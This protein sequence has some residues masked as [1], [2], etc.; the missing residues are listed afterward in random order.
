MRRV[1][2]APAPP[3]H[4]QRRLIWLSVSMTRRCQANLGAP[5]AGPRTG[6]WVSG[7]AAA[8][9]PSGAA[10]PFCSQTVGPCDKTASCR[11]P[12]VVAARS[13][14]VLPGP[15]VAHPSPCRLSRPTLVAGDG[16]GPGE[17][18]PSRSSVGRALCW[19]LMEAGQGHHVA[20]RQKATT[21]RGSTGQA[22]GL[23]RRRASRM[24]LINLCAIEQL[25][26]RGGV[27]TSIVVGEH[28]RSRYPGS[29]FVSRLHWEMPDVSALL[30]A[31]R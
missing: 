31:P 30:S 26:T 14:R 15:S 3:A 19:R 9:L 7:P 4:P 24:E 6:R 10:P 21:G 29:R 8:Q 1:A 5:P 20:C 12:A 11:Q 27:W 22:T 13:R 28:E 17:N 18:P 25:H 23:R 2:V 16:R